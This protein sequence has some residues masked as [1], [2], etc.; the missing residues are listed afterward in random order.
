MAAD[1]FR[2]DGR[3]AL[4]T[5]GAHGLG[6]LIA[7]G[8]LNAGAEVIITSRRDA[9]LVA[10]EMGARCTGLDADLSDARGA[11]TL[12]E[13]V[14]D[15]T[16]A[17]HILVNNAGRTLNADLESYPDEAWDAIMPINV[18]TPFILIRD[19]LPR[20]EAAGRP[21]DPARI[22]NIGSVAGNSVHRL[23]AY[24]YS[25][26]KAALHHLTRELAAELA[27]RHI[28]ANVIAPGWFSTG[29][30]AA[31]RADPQ[32]MERTRRRIPFGRFGEPSDIVGAAVFLGSPAAAYITGAMIPVDGGI[33]GCR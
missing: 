2:L 11:R 16:D 12:A 10:S 3:T 5:G 15:G 32:A 13:Q 14:V 29:M 27:S 28:A 6:R 24:A 31:V 25:A 4:V 19:L 7:Q 21:N 26:S 1:L 20:L 30:T 22:I 8:F 23:N 18:Q 17:L 33:S 9:A